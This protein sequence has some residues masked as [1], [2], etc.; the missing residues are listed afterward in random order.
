[1]FSTATGVKAY[2]QGSFGT[3][4]YTTGIVTLNALTFTPN[5]TIRLTVAPESYDVLASR[6]NI[7]VVEEN[8]TLSTVN[9]VS[10]TNTSLINTL[11]TSRGI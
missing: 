5:Q 7:L 10:S 4:D 8:Q 9:V 2:R 3:V 1:M 6:N 11:D